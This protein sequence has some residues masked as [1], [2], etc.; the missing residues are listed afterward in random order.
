[1][2]LF[3]PEFFSALLAIVVIDLVLAGDN[4]IVIALAARNLPP[5]LRT[6]AI[7]WGTVGA[8]AVRTAM[9]VVVVWLLKIP[10]LLLAGGALLLWIAYKL[11][12]NPDNGDEHKVSPATNFWGAMRTIVVADAVMGLDNVLA[13]AGAAHGNV[14]LVVLGLLISIPIVIW[15]SQLIL[16]YVQKYPAIVYVG[17][18]VLVWTGVKMMTSEPLIKEPVTAMGNWIWALYA[19]GLGGVLYAGFH[20]NHAKV[21]ER[22]AAHVVAH[23]TDLA[24]SAEGADAARRPAADSATASPAAGSGM[25]KV[26][27]PVDDAAYSLLAVRHVAGQVLSGGQVEVHLLHVRTPFSR[28]VSQFAS[29]RNRDSLHRELAEKVLQPARALLQQHGIAHAVHIGVGEIAPAIDHAARRLHVDKI[30]MGTAPKNSLMRLLQ[31][32]V[33]HSVLEIT[34]VPVEVVA[35]G[36]VSKLERYGVPAGIGAAVVALMVTAS[37]S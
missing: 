22:V 6:K 37:A 28:H 9:T 32:S 4:A 21:R 8:I 13:V 20:A 15:G 14:L 25:R 16:K 10:G 18:G 5:H 34:R 17:A 33:T 12:I 35:G 30:V 31:D 26:L 36:Q 23:V 24:D 2:E 11:L 19:A 7:A 29:R 27:I 3:S 1:M